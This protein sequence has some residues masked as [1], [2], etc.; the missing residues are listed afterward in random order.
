MQS[1]S[2]QE[3]AP[4][5][6]RKRRRPAKVAASEARAAGL[7]DPH[8]TLNLAALS[9]VLYFLAL[10]G[11]GAWP[12]A[13]V[14]Q[15][16]LLVALRGQTPRR[17][18]LVGFVAGLVM[19]ASGYY[20]LVGTLQ[21]F[22]ELSAFVAL[23]LSAVLWA[24]MAGRMALLGWL[25]TRAEERGWPASLAFALAFGATELV[26]PL[27]FPWFYAVTV[28]GV[29]VLEQLA[30]L[31][32]PYVVSLVLLG[33]NLALAE[34]VIARREARAFDRRLVAAG[35]AVPV[36]AAAYGLA[37]IPSVDVRTAAAR[38][39]RVG[40]AQGNQPAKGRPQSAATYR[41]LTAD[42]RDEGV[43][44][45]V[46]PEGALPEVYPEASYREDLKREVTG[47]L[48]VPVIFG[49]GV[50]REVRGEKRETNTAFVADAS[51][52]V[53]GRYDKHYLLPFGEYLP[54]GETFPSLYAYAPN[55]S[56]LLP[57]ESIA[58]LEWSGRSFAPLICY[59]D[60]LPQFVNRMVSRGNPDVLV[61][62]T[63]DTWFGATTEPWS[64]LALAELRAIEHRRFL[65]RATNSGVSAVVDPVGR[66][67]VES[68]LFREETLVA[69]V[70]PL[71]G[72]T[73]YELLGDAPMWAVSAVAF[74][75]A[76]RRRRAALG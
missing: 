21:R 35:L 70:R 42:L 13:F 31:G 53:V 62:L 38:A 17:G 56:R 34:L 30:E 2:G 50:V 41:R 5:P 15:A 16:P 23:A 1:A 22:G 10:P 69:E 68:A 29:P 32:G 55:T 65:V 74:A 19:A 20:W 40:L 25:T 75:L 11:L 57:G 24:Q 33:P 63:I 60:I 76:F 67:V 9:G 39:L 51:G 36:L 44:L 61:N 27:L 66:V 64:H 71:H 52:E 7:F 3:R 4:A 12:L 26:Y 28:H 8:F 47:A 54:L 59:E 43:D 37:R 6:R 72:K 73:V 48:G 46:W 18:A 49:G 58:P 14:A 45:V